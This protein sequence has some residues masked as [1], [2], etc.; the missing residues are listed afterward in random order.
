MIKNISM[1]STVEL[2]SVRFNDYKSGSRT[3]SLAC[4]IY[5]FIDSCMNEKM[6]MNRAYFLLLFSIVKKIPISAKLSRVSMTLSLFT[7]LFTT[8]PI[9]TLK[10]SDNQPTHHDQITYPCSNK[11]RNK[12]QV[13]VSH[14]TRRIAGINTTNKNIK[15]YFIKVNDSLT[16]CETTYNSMYLAYWSKYCSRWLS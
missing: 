13:Q 1:W 9:S 12:S 16:I 3:T 7:A 11:L 2:E 4:F 8:P 15:L 6:S 10:L 5:V 14:I